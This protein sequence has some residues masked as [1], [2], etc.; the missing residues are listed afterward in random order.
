MDFIRGFNFTGEMP[1]TSL[2]FVFKGQRILVRENEEGISIPLKSDL[3][4]LDLKPSEVQYFGL[5]DESPCFTGEIVDQVV[6]GNGLTLRGIR[7][8]FNVIDKNVLMVA[9]G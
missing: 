2:W 9:G 7:S 8:L 1:E 5:L 3:D 6:P 4:E